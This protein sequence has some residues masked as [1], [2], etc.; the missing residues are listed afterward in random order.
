MLESALLQRP[1]PCQH[2]LE[3]MSSSENTGTSDAELFSKTPTQQPFCS[4]TLFSSKCHQTL[5]WSWRPSS[6]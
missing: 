6:L 1:Y 2:P 4:F 5:Q 3:Q